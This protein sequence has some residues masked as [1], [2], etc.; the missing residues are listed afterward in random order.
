MTVLDTTA[1]SQFLRRPKAGVPEHPCVAMLRKLLERG[2]AVCVPGIV[3]QEL[4]SGVR[5]ET[6]FQSLLK[7]LAGFPLFLARAEHHLRAAQ[8]ANVA[9]SRGVAVST[10][11]CLIAAQAIEMRARLMTTD[12]DFQRMAQFSDLRIIPI[13]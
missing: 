10:T 5:T 6:Q 9:R 3:Y 2:E 12:R 7:S 13:P 8:L 1:L 11:D 4:L